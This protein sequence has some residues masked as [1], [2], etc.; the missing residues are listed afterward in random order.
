MCP[1]H[2]DV[3]AVQKEYVSS[4]RLTDELDLPKRK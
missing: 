2:G 3:T 4:G 1:R